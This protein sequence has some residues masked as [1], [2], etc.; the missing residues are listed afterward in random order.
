M[1]LI[2]VMPAKGIYRNRYKGHLRPC[3]SSKDAL[4]KTFMKKLFIFLLI[5]NG[6]NV[7]GQTNGTVTVYNL[8]DSLKL[9]G[10]KV[11]IDFLAQG[12]KTL[13]GI[14]DTNVTFFIYGRTRHPPEI[15]F[16]GV[17]ALLK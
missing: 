6:S 10:A 12:L 16:R 5:L 14:T 17:R 1:N 15:S 13:K 8:S 9:E 3:T 2:R 4:L 7:L 11:E